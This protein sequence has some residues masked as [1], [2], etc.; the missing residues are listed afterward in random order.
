MQRLI[1]LASIFLILCSTAV[2][3]AAPSS[4]NTISDIN[5]SSNAAQE[6]IQLDFTSEFKESISTDFENG[7]IQLTFPNTVFNPSLAYFNV[8]DRFIQS[9]RLIKAAGSSIVEIHF[10]D[11]AFDAMGM[12]KEKAEGNRVTV[13]VNKSAKFEIEEPSQSSALSTEN[14]N[15]SDRQTSFLSSDTFSGGDM[16]T[17]IVKMLVAL[18]LL[19]LFFYLLLW[20]YNRFFATRFRFNKGKYDIKVSSTCHISPKQK[21][22]VLEVNG[23]AYACGV[24]ANSISVIS[25]VSANSFSDYLSNLNLSAGNEVSFVDIRAQYLEDKKRQADLQ[26][27][28]KKPDSKFASELLQRVKNL[29]PLD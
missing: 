22:I 13:L 27:D 25:K 6:Q 19:L 17:N 10:A 23:A 15:Q 4:D 12:I 11:P 7:L 2:Y 24:T 16:T 18:F 26:T 5:I 9:I 21:V 14:L 8:N 3:A 28:P 29:K 1:T 20:V